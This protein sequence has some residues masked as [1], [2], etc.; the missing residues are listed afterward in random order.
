MNNLFLYSFQIADFG[1]SKTISTYPIYSSSVG[2][3]LYSSPEIVQGK[4]YQGPECDVWSLGVILY[5]MLT[6][7]MPFDDSNMGQFFVKIENGDYP[8]P[9]GVSNGRFLQHNMTPLT[10]Q[11]E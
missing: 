3:L 6:A 11:V 8:A 7:S 9:L 4:P 2:S 1:F 5:T 10:Y